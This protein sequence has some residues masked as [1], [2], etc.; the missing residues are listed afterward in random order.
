M[1]SNARID[2]AGF[3]RGNCRNS[4]ESGFRTGT[5]RSAGHAVSKD[6][7]CGC[8]TGWVEHIRAAGFKTKVIEM[9][10]LAP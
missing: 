3:S 8:C 10:D 6:P 9:S 7:N 2:Q 4:Y 5:R 1:S